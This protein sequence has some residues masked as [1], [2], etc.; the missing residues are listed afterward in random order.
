MFR[1]IK[2]AVTAALLCAS[3]ASAQNKAVVVA[4]CG[5]PPGTYAPGETRPLTIGTDGKLCDTIAATTGAPADAHYYTNQVESGLSAEVVPAANVITLLGSADNA[6]MRTNL[7]L[8]IGTNVQAFDSD[9]TTFAAITPNAN[10]QTFLGAADYAA[11]R[12][13]L[14]L[15]IGSNVQAF[16]SDLSTYAG[17]TPSTNIQTLLGSANFAA[18]R[19]N[20]GTP[21]PNSTYITQTADSTLSAEQALG[22]LATGLVKNT[23]TTG[24]LSIATAGT[25]YQEAATPYAAG[26]WYQAGVGN[27]AVGAA[28]SNGLA[29]CFPF[30]IRHTATISDLGGRVSTLSV[31]GDVQFAI[32][33]MSVTTGLPTGTALAVTGDIATTLAV[34]VSADITGANVTLLTGTYWECVNANNGT[35]V[36]QAF[37]AATT[38]AGSTAGALDLNIV[39]SAA[40]TSIWHL[41]TTLT[42]GTWSD[43]TAA[44]F[45]EVAT[46][47]FAMMFF[48]AA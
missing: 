16:D 11:M 37:G 8:T 20:L 28:L 46:A 47:A 19:T 34:T 13:Q 39:S 31:G 40:A 14:A 35:I 18:A 3:S 17:I 27:A 38:Y 15:T 22:S 36:M 29:R 2:L 24:V 48:K 12:T 41:E 23:T 7:G 45:T 30:I 33:A 25:D 1:A 44:S 21:P 32:Y 10:T 26:R 4:N 5:T 6:A 9:L 43:L 42:F